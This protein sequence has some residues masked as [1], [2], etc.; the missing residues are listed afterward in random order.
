MKPENFI[1][2]STVSGFFISIIFAILK[3]LSFFDFIFF[4]FFMTSFFYILS[5][6][7]VTF[8]IK[9]AIVSK[10]IKFNKYKVEEIINSQ[11]KIL[12]E[13]ENFLYESYEF[14]KK[15]EEEELKFLKK[16]NE[17]LSK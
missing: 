3:D 16:K 7:S 6:A 11:I 12:E 5:F 1:Y 13:K 17:S 8:F 10:I 4:V 2:F 15:I 9:Y 14:L